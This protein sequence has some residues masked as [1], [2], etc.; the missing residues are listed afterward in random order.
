MMYATDSNP[1]R[2]EGVALLIFV[3]FLVLGAMAYFMSGLSVEELKQHQIENTAKSLQRAKQALI[4]YAI[5]Y[6]DID[7]DGDTL[8]DFPGEYG[9][10]PCP[11]YSPAGFFEGLEDS[12]NCGVRGE[13]K[14]GFFPWKTLDV[15]VLRDD[16]GTCLLYA[17]TGEYK[18]DESATPNKTLMLNEDSNGMF[19]IVDKTGVIVQGAAAENRVVA[20]VFAPGKVLSGQNRTFAAGSLCGQEYAQLGEY[21]DAGGGADNSDVTAAADTIDQFI[22]ATAESVADTNPNPY[23]DR[24]VTITRDEIWSAIVKRADLKKKMTEMTEALAMCLANYATI[25]GNNRLPWPVDATILAGYRDT[26]NYDDNADGTPGYAG[27]YP[28]NVANSNSVIP[29]PHGSSELFIEAGCNA[30]IVTSGAT[31]D[32][33]TPGSEY[34]TLWENWKDHFFYAV[35][36]DYAPDNTAA[37]CGTNCITVQTIPRAAMVVFSGFRQ[38]GETRNEPLA[39]DADTK[40][41]VSQYIENTNAALFPDLSGSGNYTATTSNDIMYCLTTASPPTAVPC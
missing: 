14:I 34:R 12:G 9:F 41:D 39:G 27:R 11:D 24:F 22:H 8:P 15:P 23:N 38:P 25:N 6:G 40:S 17:V 29:G 10:L 1:L 28:Y 26:N 33:Q 21:L 20:I 19:Q 2:Q 4:A 16:S 37:S 30:M 18:N 36:K 32:L 35:S 7:G 3:I 13:S 5:T 31:V